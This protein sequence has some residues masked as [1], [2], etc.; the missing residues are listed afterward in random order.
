[1]SKNR[2]GCKW[3][4]LACA[5]MLLASGCAMSD[6]DGAD[7]KF[8]KNITDNPYVYQD[9]EEDS[10]VTMYLTV[11]RGSEGAPTDHTWAEVNAEGHSIFYYRDLGIDRYQVEAI[12]QVGGENGPIEV[13][14]PNA[15]VQ[16]RGNTTSESAQKSF[17]IELNDDAGEWRGQSTIA[18]NKHPY[19]LTRI[20]NKLA[21]DLMK[22]IPD[23]IGFRTQFVRLYVKDETMGAAEAAFVDYGLFTQ[24][25]QP[26][27]KYLGNHGLDKN[28]QFYKPGFF[29]F[30]RYEDKIKMVDDPAF[31]FEAFEYMIETKGNDDHA[32][33]I[34][35][36]E[37]L[38]NYDIPIET[39]FE[40]YFNADNYFT[41]MAFQILTGN[42]DTTSRNYMLYSPEESV[43]WYFVTWDADMMLNW[44]QK[45]YR[46]Q[47]VEGQTLPQ[48]MYGYEVGVSNYWGIVLHERVLQV[49]KYR[50]RLNQTIE[51]MREK[52]L[53]EDRV[54]AWIELYRP[55]VT[56]LLYTGADQEYM[57]VTQAE[58]DMLLESLPKELETSYQFYKESLMKPMPFFLG[59]PEAYGRDGLRFVWEPAYS[60]DSLRITYKAEIATAKEFL[61]EDIVLEQDGLTYP[62]LFIQMLPN[63]RYF[64]R[65]TATDERGY[66]QKALDYYVGDDFIHRYGMRDF[67]IQDGEVIV[68][69]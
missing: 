46:M 26:N 43:K 66:S 49:P 48:D 12:L 21:Y 9:D 1:M 36:L 11:R 44:F 13:L 39:T 41:W 42:I 30:E 54:R 63:G 22:G 57:Q 65:V 45:I 28:G 29:E 40:K 52:Y 35:M 20:K 62:A 19:D 15:V 53:T 69:E 55:T 33:L 23:M 38:N 7:I 27:R 56:A 64:L 3:G 10:L 17:K 67:E 32:K 6:V 50:E 47:T 18:L 37:E 25:E 14:E 31:D 61:P 60:F 16:I 24:V 5:V 8:E 68:V 34:G 51:W 58:F 2:Q 4:A 59:T